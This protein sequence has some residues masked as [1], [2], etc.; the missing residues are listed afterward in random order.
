MN[1]LG[2]SSRLHGCRKQFLNIFISPFKPKSDQRQ[3]SPYNII[4]ESHVKVMRIKEM[5]TNERSFWLVNKF[6]L[7]APLEMYREQYGEYTYWR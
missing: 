3:I 2:G 1:N 7:S 6:S 5:I 4:L